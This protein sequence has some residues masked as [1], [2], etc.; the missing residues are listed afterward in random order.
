MVPAYTRSPVS[1][2]TGLERHSRQQRLRG[3]VVYSVTLDHACRQRR[4]RIQQLGRVGRGALSALLEKPADEQ[5]ENECRQPIEVDGTR[6]VDRV[7]ETLGPSDRQRDCDRKVHVQRSRFERR[8]RAG[9]EHA[10]R[11]EQGRGREQKAHPAKESFVR[12]VHAAELAAVQRQRRE[13]HVRRDGAGHADPRQ[14]RP[15]LSATHGLHL[16]T[17]ERMRVVA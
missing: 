1:T 2:E 5:R 14:H 15:I 6:V 13:H 8:P 9:E 17:A 11:S 4:Q 3:Q 10:P 7:R 16:E 12:S